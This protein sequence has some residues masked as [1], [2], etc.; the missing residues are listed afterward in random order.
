MYDN[1]EKRIQAENLLKEVQKQ[2]KIL[3]EN[4]ESAYEDLPVLNQQ[5]NKLNTELSE[6]N[7]Q[8]GQLRKEN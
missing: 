7:E 3:S 4:L 5:I 1:E 8:L 6:K 2:N